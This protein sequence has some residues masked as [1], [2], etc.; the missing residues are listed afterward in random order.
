MSFEAALSIFHEFYRVMMPG[1]YLRIVLP[2]LEIYA[3]RYNE[4][5]ANG[6]MCMPYG[7]LD[8]VQGLYSPAMSLNRI[9][10][11][12]GHQFIY[13]FATLSLA[14]STTGFI[15]IARRHFGESSDPGLVFDTAERAIESLYVEAHKPGRA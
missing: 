13:D 8:T 12:Y 9:F 14:L 10:R 5:R 6:T 11:A 1:A 3:D 2:D 7:S 4:F 15:D